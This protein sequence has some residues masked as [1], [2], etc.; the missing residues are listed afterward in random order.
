MSG[1]STVTIEELGSTWG[2]CWRDETGKKNYG[3]ENCPVNARTRL[4]LECAGGDAVRQ[5]LNAEIATIINTS[6][7]AY[8]G[9]ER[10]VSVNI[11]TF[12]AVC[13]RYWDR[14]NA[15]GQVQ[16]QQRQSCHYC[17]QTSTRAGFFGEATCEN[18]S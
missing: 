2:C 7:G 13:D 8:G 17:G 1:Q 9:E 11:A 10:T 14:L 12:E 15:Q 4:W 18:C 6:K 5:L 3:F 16:E